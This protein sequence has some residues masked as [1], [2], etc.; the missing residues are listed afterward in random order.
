MTE[1]LEEQ[2][3]TEPTSLVIPLQCQSIIQHHENYTMS[4]WS[5]CLRQ[6]YTGKRL[7]GMSHVHS[8][9]HVLV[10]STI[11]IIVSNILLN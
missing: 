7:K 11:S 2:S 5:K 8:Q 4:V 10:S 1:D 6:L 3:S 9:E